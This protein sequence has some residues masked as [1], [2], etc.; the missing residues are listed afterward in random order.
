MQEG[1]RRA[2]GLSAHG[3]Q[4]GKSHLAAAQNGGLGGLLQ[5]HILAGHIAGHAGEGDLIPAGSVGAEHFHGAAAGDLGQHGGRG[6]TVS[7]SLV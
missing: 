7:I 5:I 1:N 2:R 3:A 4:Q 6:S